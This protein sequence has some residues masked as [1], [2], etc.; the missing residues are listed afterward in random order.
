MEQYAKAG[1]RLHFTNSTVADTSASFLSDRKGDSMLAFWTG[2][3]DPSLTYQL[4]F[5]AGSYYNPS[6]VEALPE[7]GPAL[8]ATRT[9]EDIDG[10]RKAFATLQ[11]LVT[12]NALVVPLVFQ[13]EMDA[14][15]LGVKGYRPNLLG[16][17]KFEDVYLE[18]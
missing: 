10:R 5:G 14:H 18:G 15:R 2:R 1:I 16:K 8:L 9:A 12:E 6:R 7:I 13:P 11:R 17:P 3:P 4:L